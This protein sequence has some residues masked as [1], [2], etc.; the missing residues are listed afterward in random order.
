MKLYNHQQKLIDLAPDRHLLAWQTGSGKTATAINLIEGD[1]IVVCPKSLVEN[2]FEELRMW[3]RVS[4]V[5]S[6]E[7][8][9][10]HAETLDRYDTLIIDEAHFFSGPKSQLTKAILKFIKRVKPKRILLLTATPYMS[11]P[12]NIHTLAKI[13]GYEWN[14]MKFKQ[15]FFN[16]VH[17]GARVIPVLKKGME[18][19]VAK[20]VAKIGSTV[21]LDDCFDVPEQIHQVEYFDLTK[22]QKQAI[23]AIEEVMPLVVLTKEHQICG[24]SLKGNAYQPTQY[25]ESEKLKRLMELSEQHEQMA[26]VCR[27]NAEIDMIALKFHEKYPGIKIFKITGQVDNRHEVV[28]QINKSKSCIVLINGACSEGY[29][30]PFIP[31]MVFY[32]YDFGLKNYIQMLGR[33]Q[34]ASNIKKNVYISLIVKN[35]VDERIYKTVAIEKKDFDTKIYEKGD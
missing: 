10:K 26:V 6:K 11:T 29:G 3:N 32:S 30:L 2:W 28:E 1:S 4:A 25:F 13:L 33:I 12:W 15:F 34:R 18:P 24:G 17:M 16:D 19:E 20:L 21:S 5:F 22:E 9:K 7:K 8:F 27:Y 35:T 23:S 14:W 31:L